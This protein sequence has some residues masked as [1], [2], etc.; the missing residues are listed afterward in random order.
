METRLSNGT[1]VKTLYAVTRDEDWSSEALKNRKWG[2]EGEVVSHHDSHGLCYEVRHPDGTIGC[3]DPTEL[4]VL[5]IVAVIKHW[6][7][8]EPPVPEAVRQEDPKGVAQYYYTVEIANLQEFIQKHGPMII[9][10]P[11]KTP[12]SEGW[13]IWY[14]GGSPRFNQS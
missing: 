9:S 2:V 10:P 8:W 11:G 6:R 7:G 5:P 4:E 1:K 3:Y 13:F 14:N 12:Y